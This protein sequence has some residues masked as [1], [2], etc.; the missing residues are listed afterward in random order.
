MRFLLFHLLDVL[1]SVHVCFFNRDVVEFVLVRAAE[2]GDHK[3]RAADHDQRGDHPALGLG[4]GAQRGL[5]APGRPVDH[6]LQEHIRMP[7]VL[8]RSHAVLTKQLP[9]M[10]THFGAV[11]QK[12]TYGHHFSLII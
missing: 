4:G 12:P 8:T 9:T 5:E 3:P 2:D 11:S 6:H 7:A 1:P 10:S